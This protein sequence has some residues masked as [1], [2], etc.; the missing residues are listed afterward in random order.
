MCWERGRKDWRDRVSKKLISGYFYRGWNRKM[1][2]DIYF[3]IYDY[4]I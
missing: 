3:L 4:K 1:A 2:M